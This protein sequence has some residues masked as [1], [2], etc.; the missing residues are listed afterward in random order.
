[1]YWAE[2]NISHKSTTLKG[3]QYENLQC[4]QANVGSNCSFARINDISATV[5]A[6]CGALVDLLPIPFSFCGS[7]KMKSLPQNMPLEPSKNWQQP[8]APS[9]LP[10]LEPIELLDLENDETVDRFL[11]HPPKPRMLDGIEKKRYC[12][13]L[14]NRCLTFLVRVGQSST[15]ILQR[16]FDH[17]RGSRS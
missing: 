7:S 9:V 17:S 10:F 5:V 1:M 11:V 16:L 8:A 4:D 13:S 12:P 2:L 6:D 15:V 14:A 3:K